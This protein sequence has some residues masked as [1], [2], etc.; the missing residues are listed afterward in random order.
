MVLTS[1]A[2]GDVIIKPAERSDRH[3]HKTSP[4][5][6]ITQAHQPPRNTP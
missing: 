5:G 3:E 4:R 6:R 2:A 1:S